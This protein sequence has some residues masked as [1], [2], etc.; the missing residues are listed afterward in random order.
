MPN[1]CWWSCSLL[2]RRLATPILLAASTGGGRGR[3]RRKRSCSTARGGPA[4]L[5]HDSGINATDI[6]VG[7]TWRGADV[8]HAVRAARRFRQEIDFAASGKGPGSPGETSF[9]AAAPLRA[10]HG[11]ATGRFKQRHRVGAGLYANGQNPFASAGGPSCPTTVAPG[12]LFGPRG[13]H[14]R[15]PPTFLLVGGPAA[16][17]P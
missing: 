11:P 10:N 16:E 17:A 14:G 13:T 4:D 7:G 15:A 12:F 9:T 1:D 5:Q 6:L 8:V 2:S 3:P